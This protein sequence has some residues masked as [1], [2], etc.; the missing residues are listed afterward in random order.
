ME[1]ESF[2]DV[3][4]NFRISSYPLKMEN[5][6]MPP[7]TNKSH[8]IITTIHLKIMPPLFIFFTIGGEDYH[9]LTPLKRNLLGHYIILL[10]QKDPIFRDTP[11]PCFVTFFL[12][13]VS[14][15]EE[16]D[17]HMIYYISRWKKVKIKILHRTWN[18]FKGVWFLW[19]LDEHAS[20]VL[21]G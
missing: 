8:I 14:T 7:K 1:N 11:F 13:L 18:N 2:I 9:F 21:K 19:S 20:R 5:N 17:H 3:N 6:Y 16:R 12:F 15:L 4:S 10:L